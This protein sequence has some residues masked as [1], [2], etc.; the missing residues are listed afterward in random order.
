MANKN[1]FIKTEQKFQIKQ[2]KLQ[3]NNKFKGIK[4]SEVNTEKKKPQLHNR[5][6]SAERTINKFIIARQH[7]NIAVRRFVNSYIFFLFFRT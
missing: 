4:N 7:E 1:V 3:N 6:V 5:L 2:K